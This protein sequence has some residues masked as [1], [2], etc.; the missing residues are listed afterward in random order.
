MKKTDTIFPYFWHTDDTE[1][2]I[3]K[4]RIY[5]LDKQNKTIV[6]RVD[7]FT[8]YV[9]LEL[10]TVV[11]DTVI[12]WDAGKAQLLSDRINDQVGFFCSCENEIF[13]QKEIIFLSS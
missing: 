12:T 7:D 3:T 13:V 6:L 10:P 9:Y 5:A 8:P 11:N 2:E 4:M 1:K